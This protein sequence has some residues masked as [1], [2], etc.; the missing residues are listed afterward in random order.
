M[1]TKINLCDTCIFCFATCT[2]D[3]VEFGD[4]VG[5]D[6]II[7]CFLYEKEVR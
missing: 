7:E 4:G 5:G 6:N 3:E 2:C 1:D